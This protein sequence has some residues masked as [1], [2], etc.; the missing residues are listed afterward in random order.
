[1]SVAKILEELKKL[2]PDEKTQISE[3][4][5]E[6]LGVDVGAKTEP[7]EASGNN[8]GPP[9]L[10]QFSG[11]SGNKNEVSYAQW[12]F[13]VKGMQRDGT[14]S[15]GSVLQTIRRSLKGKA[16]EVLLHLGD[17]VTVKE[18]LAKLELVF[19]NVLP[20]EA[21]LERFYMARQE[22]GEN[23]ATWACRIEDLVTQLKGKDASAMPGT[24]AGMIRSKFYSGLRAGTLKSALRH[25]FDSG[26]S[27]GELLM[28]AQVVELE[29]TTEKKASAKANQAVAV[30]SQLAKKLDKVLASLDDVQ[31]RLARLEGQEPRGAGSQ[32]NQGNQ[33]QGQGSQGQGNRGK[34][35]FQP[36]PFRGNCYKCGQFG[37]P[38]F[39]CPL[40]KQQPASG[41]SGSA[42]TDGAQNQ[43]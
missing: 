6:A 4:L 9:R 31:K 17:D 13:E 2:K 33:G 21:I 15:E 20:A 38:Q 19:G 39:R 23:V 14:Y 36:R 16:G 5:G 30:D 22:E 25:K 7:A 12:S 34:Q 8:N 35:P 10:S 43:G 28:S 41:A 29:E 27:Y 40:N 11:E 32:A 1:M 37:H 26:A 3:A 42:A 24:P 18:V